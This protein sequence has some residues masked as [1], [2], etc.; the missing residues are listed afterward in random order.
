MEIL[1]NKNL[2]WNLI[3]KIIL[4]GIVRELQDSLQLTHLK[5]LVVGQVNARS[6]LAL[7]LSYNC[8]CG[9]FFIFQGWFGLTGKSLGVGLIIL[10]LF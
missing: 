4:L 7:C 5:R 8:L 9:S 6:C 2:Y 10:E 1:V 3:S